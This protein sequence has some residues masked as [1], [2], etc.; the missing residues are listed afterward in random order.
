[1]NFGQLLQEVIVEEADEG[2]WWWLKCKLKIWNRWILLLSASVTPHCSLPSSC[3]IYQRCCCKN[4]NGSLIIYFCPPG[5]LEFPDLR[6][7]LRPS[8][9]VVWG[10]CW[11]NINL[12]LY[13]SWLLWQ[14]HLAICCNLLLLPTSGL[15]FCEAQ[16]CNDPW[17]ADQPLKLKKSIIWLA[18]PG[19]GRNFITWVMVTVISR[20][21]Q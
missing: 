11:R 18:R 7:D 16:L 15:C 14:D 9:L 12:C 4:I 3:Y 2:V 5:V 8:V 10:E 21:A 17:L 19:L 13:F 1:M 20:P 6:P